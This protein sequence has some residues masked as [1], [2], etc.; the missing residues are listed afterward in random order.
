[1]A[2]LLTEQDRAEIRSAI[3]DVFDTYMKMPATLE[4]RNLG[5][6]LAAFNEQ[7]SQHRDAETFDVLCL[8][9]PDKNDEDAEAMKSRD[10]Y[11]DNTEGVIYIPV[12]TLKGTTPPL[13]DDGTGTVIT[14][15][16]DSIVIQGER[17]TIFGVNAVGPDEGTLN[18]DQST[19]YM[20]KL[21]YFNEL[22]S[23]GAGQDG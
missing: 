12:S 9:L 6:K 4:I 13:W 7:R 23:R 20:V 21:Q 5:E 3:Q 15:N 19:F 18:V 1:M 22:K 8:Y 17:L 10:G 11:F 16:R 14:A 2:D